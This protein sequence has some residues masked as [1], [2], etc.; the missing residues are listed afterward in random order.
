MIHDIKDNVKDFPGYYISREGFLYSRYDNKGRLTN[1]YHKNKLYVRSN[2][3]S[4]AVLKIRKD[5]KLRRVYI[6]RL[7][8]E[9]YIPNPYCKPCVGHIDNVRTNNNVN[10]LYWCTYKE[11]TKQC[12][13]EGRLK[14][15]S[16]IIFLA[17]SDLHLSDYAKF[18]SREDSGFKVLDIIASRCEK[19]NVPAIHLGDLLHKPESISNRLLYRIVDEFHRLSKYNWKL[20]TIS[21]NHCISEKSTIGNKPISWDRTFSK[22]FPWLKCIDYKRIHFS[23]GYLYGIPYIDNNIGI[24]EYIKKLELIGGKRSKHILMLHTDYPGAKDTDGSEVNS[25]ENLNVNLLSKFDLVLC[26]HIHKPQRLGKKVYM[27]GAPYQQRRT[28]KNCELGY[29][30]VYSDMSL[31][32]VPL[33]GFP[34]FIDVSSEDE[35]KDDGNYYIVIASKSGNMEVEDTSRITRELSKKSIV[36]KYMRVKGIKDKNRKNIL[37]KVIKEAE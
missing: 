11:N 14:T 2:G 12:I 37:L 27:I 17:F 1:K 16:K 26:G 8:A 6:H 28:D 4:Q 5:N 3:Y 34:K 32:F 33:K 21:G 30:E 25:V 31:K 36:R 20:Y 10:N 7:V 29:W 23:K 19:L 15:N 24:S 13:M 9:T 22:L 18:P 35:I